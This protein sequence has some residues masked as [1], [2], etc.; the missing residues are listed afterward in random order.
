M[1]RKLLTALIS[2]GLITLP[3]QQAK[4]QLVGGICIMLVATVVCGTV[5]VMVRHCSP[6]YAVVKDL[7]ELDKDCW[8]QITPTRQEVQINNWITTGFEYASMEACEIARKKDCS[9]VAGPAALYPGEVEFT[10]EKSTNLVDWIT[11]GTWTG[12]PT[13]LNWCETNSMSS[14]WFY[15]VRY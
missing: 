1:K 12:K 6:K 13:S 15:R 10:I 11:A 3:V 14:S 9:P 7:D 4:P 5:V 8:C 2:A